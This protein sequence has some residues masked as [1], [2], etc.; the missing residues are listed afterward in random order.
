MLSETS[1]L[2]HEWTTLQNNHEQYERHGLLIRLVSAVLF[3]AC[4]VLPLDAVIPIAVVVILWVQEGILRTGQ[5]RLGD[6]ILRIEQMLRQATPQLAYACQL[7]TEWQAGR[8]GFAGLLAEYAK[9][10]LKPTVAFH[11]AVLAL[12]SLG[13]AVTR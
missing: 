13:A 11:Y 12:L 8:P 5:S 2:V 4:L 1:P 9:N 10:M 3:V 7:H 6:R